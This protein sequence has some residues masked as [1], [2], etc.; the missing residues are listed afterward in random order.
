MKIFFFS[1]LIIVISFTNGKFVSDENL[2][3]EIIMKNIDACIKWDKNEPNPEP[4]LQKIRDCPCIIP[5][6]F[7][8]EIYDGAET[9]KTD[10]GCM[11][12]KQPKTC[13]YH[14]GAY[15]CYRHAFKSSGPGAQCCYD[16]AGNWM[17]D[18]FQGAGTLDRERAPDSILSLIQLKKHNDHD[19]IPWNNC[20]K[21]TGMA[22]DYCR[23]YFNKRPPGKCQNYIL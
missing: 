9:W 6:S 10:A 22:V 18:P 5:T 13:E 4:L 15:G 17:S 20:C 12:S 19:V 7:P 8:K 21:N 16:K 11:A 1:T 2:R 14:K 3:T 23:L